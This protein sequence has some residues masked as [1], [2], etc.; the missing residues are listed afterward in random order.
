M[1]QINDAGLTLIERSE[2]LRLKAYD[3]GTGVWTIGYGH[4]RGVKRGDVITEEQAAVFL[5]EDLRDAEVAV[6]GALADAGLTVNDNQFS[7]LVSFAFNLGGGTV[8]KLL[9]IPG[10]MLQYN[11]AGG[12]VMLGLTRRR[13]AERDLFLKVD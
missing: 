13:K 11:H 7:A 5:R 1:R 12:K 2:G 9:D 8:H 3:D 10:R 6:E 4:T